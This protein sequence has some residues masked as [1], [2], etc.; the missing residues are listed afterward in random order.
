MKTS[1]TLIYKPQVIEALNKAEIT[2]EARKAILSFEK[3]VNSLL[4][5]RDN[6]TAWVTIWNSNP[7]KK[8]YFIAQDLNA[9]GTVGTGTEPKFYNEWK[10]YCDVR[11]FSYDITLGDCLA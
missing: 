1:W 11:G 6:G 4:T 10:S 3:A 9:N 8:A 2:G 5:L 7:A